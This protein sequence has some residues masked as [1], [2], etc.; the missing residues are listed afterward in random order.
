M[1][2]SFENLTDFWAWKRSDVMQRFC[3]AQYDWDEF[4]SLWSKYRDKTDEVPVKADGDL[5]DYYF[6]K[7]AGLGKGY[8]VG[9]SESYV[10][11]Y[12]KK[13]VL[14]KRRLQRHAR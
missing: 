1:P 7:N 6:W 4:Q 14:P 8:F 13:I 5:T 3:N 11:S 10:E 9:P 2:T 12:Y